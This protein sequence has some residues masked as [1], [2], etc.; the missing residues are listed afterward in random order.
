[1]TAGIVNYA[2]IGCGVMGRI[3]AEAAL[4]DAN[5][6]P[7]YCVDIDRARAEDLAGKVRAKAS[8]DY[9]QVLADPDLDAVIVC[10][11]H[12]LHRGYCVKAAQAGKH[13]M[14]E[15]PIAVTLAEA[16]EMISAAAAANVQL[17][18]A[19]V[20]RLDPSLIRVKELV[21]SGKLGR[22]ILARIHSHGY[23]RESQVQY[24]YGSWYHNKGEGGAA[25]G[26]AI[27]HAD[28]VS[29]WLGR[30]TT[31]TGFEL[32]VRP[33]YGQANEPDF[34][35]IVYEFEGGALGET[36]YGY[37]VHASP[38]N[39]LPFAVISFELGTLTIMDNRESR[40]Y[41]SGADPEDSRARVEIQPPPRQ[42][43]PASLEVPRF[44]D[45]ILNGAPLFIT[46]GEARRALELILASSESART[47]RTVAV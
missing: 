4:A 16:D 30:T 39:A 22:P 35:L 34:S 42:A 2:V 23:V 12:S 37:G 3:H 25:L 9:E 18:V 10:L 28:L 17:L 7:L 11:P 20:L 27:H 13:V 24:Q 26:G 41:D 14:V 40:L 32:S 31:V 8:T 38:A 36:T 43:S 46:P 45:S 29:W 1:M 5:S 6:N 33:E 44:S 21:Q 47:H 15:K 19:H